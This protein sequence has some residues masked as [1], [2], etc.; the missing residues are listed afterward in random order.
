MTN[1]VYTGSIN[2]N[3]L[4]SITLTNNNTSGTTVTT[5]LPLNTTGKYLG[6][7]STNNTVWIDDPYKTNLSVTGNASF[8]GD[9]TI[10]GISLTERLD[11]IEERLA[12]L[13]PNLELEDKWEKLKTLGEEYRQLEKEILEQE[14]VWDIL[15]K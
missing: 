15:K 14:K 6:V 7:D 3:M 12:I 2:G 13:R 10:K 9:I 11:K 4:G 1:S 8:S 5:A